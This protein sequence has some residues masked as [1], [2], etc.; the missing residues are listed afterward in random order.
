MQ[1]IVRSTYGS[2]DALEL[3]EVDRPVASDDEVLI[4]VVAAGMNMADVDYLRGQPHLARVGTGLRRPRNSGLGLDV[5]GHVEAVGKNVGR[6]QPGDEVFGDLTEYGFGAF[7]EYVCAHE[8]AFALKPTSLTF[9]EAAAVPQSAVMALQGLRG[10]RRIRPG[11]K[12]LVN[13]A[14]GGV[15]LF[16]VQIAKSFGAEVTA[17]DNPGKLDMVRSIGA[18]HTIDY[19]REDF[20]RTGLR[21]DRILDV[22]PSRSLFDYRRALM[23]KGRYVVIPDSMAQVFQAMVLGPLISVVGR[24]KIGMLRWAPFKREDVS[25]LTDLIDAGKVAPV[26]D[27]RY[28][29]REVPEA[30]RYQEEGHT[31]GKVVITVAAVD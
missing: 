21:Y 26:I 27:R 5:A 24:R 9:E 8:K 14:G 12:V 17:V 3:E 10:R 23:P 7:A 11:H 22:A 19:T 20:T 16:A 18:D 6:I 4:R 1:A 15:G 30:L 13:G 31:Q 2:P 28:P 25:F 29:L